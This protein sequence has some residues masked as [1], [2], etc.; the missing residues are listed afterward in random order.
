MKK[1]SEFPKNNRKEG[2][3]WENL[4]IILLVIGA[5]L[6]LTAIWNFK[7]LEEEKLES[8]PVLASEPI[9]IEETEEEK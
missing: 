9:A 5:I 7:K 6:M 8:L 4:P 1:E 2:M 3:D